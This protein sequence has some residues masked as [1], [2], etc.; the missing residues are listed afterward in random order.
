MLDPEV[1]RQAK[2]IVSDRYHV[3][4]NLAGWRGLV[5]AEAKKIENNQE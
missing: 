3:D 4:V 2:K 1:E 5:I